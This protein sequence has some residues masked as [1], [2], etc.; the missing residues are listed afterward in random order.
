MPPE[1]CSHFYAVSW[2][3]IF[4]KHASSESPISA[5]DGYKERGR[6]KRGNR[7]EELDE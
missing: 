4:P 7:N 5:P 6:E 3:C 1:K 2:A